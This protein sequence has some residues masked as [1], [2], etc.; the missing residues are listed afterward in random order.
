MPHGD[1]LET[2]FNELVAQIDAEERRKMRAAAKKGARTRRP[3]RS[4]R[5][6]GRADHPPDGRPGHLGGPPR[7]IGR[8]WL[9]MATITALIA[10]AGVVITFRPDLLAPS[11]AIPEETMPVAAAPVPEETQPVEPEPA[12]SQPVE[13]EP[14]AGPFEGSKAEDYAEGVAGF[15]MPEAKAIGGLSKKDVAKGLERA[16]QLLAASR[17]HR[18]TLMGGEPKPFIALLYPE[19]R[20]WFRK[21]LH[22]EGKRN[23]RSWVT[24]FAPKTAEPASDVIKVNGRTKLSALKKDG[25]TGAKLETNYVIV[26]AIRRPGQ[27]GTTMRLVV[28]HRG[29]VLVYRD[30]RGLVTW[31]ER[32]GGSATPARCDVPDDGYIHPFYRDSVPDK[33]GPAGAP[34]DPYDLDAPEHKG[35]CRP[36]TGA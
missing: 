23:T 9:A 8:A 27:P 29:S 16:R 33:E 25:I 11:G 2:R 17:L 14:V 5:P 13:S 30:S 21:N 19:E 32:W 3:S 4:E 20:S 31:V 15:V 22:R 36:S 26:Y 35:E 7:R 10:A 6:P 24:S 12:E 34:V 28:H 1:D 18:K